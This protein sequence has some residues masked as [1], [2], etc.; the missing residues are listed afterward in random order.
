MLKQTQYTPKMSQGKTLQRHDLNITNNT[1][2]HETLF[3]TLCAW[4]LTCFVS[5]IHLFWEGVEM[6]RQGVKIFEL[7]KARMVES[8]RL[9]LLLPHLNK[10]MFGMLKNPA[11]LKGFHSRE[12]QHKWAPKTS[13]YDKKAKRQ[14]LFHGFKQ[15]PSISST[16]HVGQMDLYTYKTHLMEFNTRTHTHTHTNIVKSNP[17]VD[18]ILSLINKTPWQI[19]QT[20]P[21]H[22]RQNIKEETLNS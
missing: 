19:N 13:P 18:R 9:A 17:L 16:T 5:R 1:T 7:L 6:G 20:N 14:H 11:V 21:N 8:S 12:P 4:D 2:H 22:A 10:E 15:A 3:K